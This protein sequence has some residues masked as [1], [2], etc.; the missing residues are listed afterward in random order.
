MHQMYSSTKVILGKQN[1]LLPILLLS[2]I[3][4]LW[5]WRGSISGH[6][7]I[8][9]LGRMEIPV[10]PFFQQDLLWSQEQLGTSNDTI[11]SA[12]CA[13]SA[14]AMVLR[15][16]GD[17]VD[18]KKLNDYLI[19]HNG[20]EGD[21]WIKWEV[22]ATFPPNKAIHRY[23]D[24]PSYGLIDWNLLWGNP[25]IIR[26]RRP[27]GKTHF[28]LLVGKEGLDYLV[29]DPG[30]KGRNGIYPFYELRTP[31]EALRFYQKK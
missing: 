2:T 10:N 8:P 5:F 18:P 11:G 21:A 13:L 25:V 27:T 12:G 6:G 23:E 1:T 9:I 19:E 14:A 31:I 28:L 17:D 29:L 7:G 15:F 3:L 20:Y 4:T 22:A 26:I 30:E 16:Y 24:Y